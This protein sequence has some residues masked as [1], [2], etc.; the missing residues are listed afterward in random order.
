MQIPDIQVRLSKA[1]DSAST[2]SSHLVGSQVDSDFAS[3]VLL[4][5]ED[6][7]DVVTPS[8]HVVAVLNM[9][10]FR[11]FVR[12]QREI[13]IRLEGSV[14]SLLSWQSNVS[15]NDADSRC[16]SIDVLVFGYRSQAEVVAAKLAASSFFLQDPDYIPTGFSYEN[17]QCLDLPDVAPVDLPMLDTSVIRKDVPAIE[18]DLAQDDDFALDFDRILD[19]FACHDGLVQA[20]AV[21]Q[22]STAL[23]R[24]I[25]SGSINAHTDVLPVIKKRA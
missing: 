16:C 25:P 15:Q 11:S 7:C 8:G 10:S 23:L 13:T 2:L 18:L 9:S 24:Y 20:S 5:A 14:Q 1:F 3:L 21:A 19:V 6:R 22:I 4:F 17:P 12:I